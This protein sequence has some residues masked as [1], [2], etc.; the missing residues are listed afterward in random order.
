[1]FTIAIFNLLP[2]CSIWFLIVKNNL[3]TEC[4]VRLDYHVVIMQNQS[5][6][7]YVQVRY[8]NFTIAILISILNVQ[9]G[10]GS[11]VRVIR[12]RHSLCSGK[13]S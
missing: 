1:M 8:L 12:Q 10:F 7:N 5:H 2:E 13:F 9:L 4:S 3:H 11:H 6:Y